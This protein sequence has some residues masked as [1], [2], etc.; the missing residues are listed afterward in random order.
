MVAVIRAVHHAHQHGVLHRD[1]KPSN[2]LVDSQGTRLV[3]DFGLAKRLADAELADRAGPAA[4]HP[5][6]HGPRAGRRPQGPDRRGRR[7]QPGRDPLRAIHRPDAVHGRQCPDAA[8]P[9]ARN[10]AAPAS[11]IRPG[12]TATWKRSSSSAWRR[13]RPVVP[14]C[15]GPGRRPR[16]LAGRQADHR[17]ADRVAGAG[18]EVGQAEPGGG[19]LCRPRLALLLV[20][21]AG[22]LDRWRPSGC[23]PPPPGRRKACTSRRSRSWSARPTRASPWCWPWR[24]PSATQARSPTTPYSP[25]WRPTMSCG[26]SSATTAR[27]RW[28]PSPPTAGPPLPGSDDRTARLWDLDSGRLLATLE[29]DAP[30]IA[31]RFRPD[32]RRL[33]T[34]SSKYYGPGGYSTNAVG[35]EDTPAK[36]APTVRVWDTSTGERLAA[37]PRP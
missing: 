13:T 11:S 27:S 10:G 25:R 34:F 5:A 4:R 16:S 7:L 36:D 33:V 12:W 2:V 14:E 35:P 30:L 6:V 32:G 17:P 37:W 29:H 22:R 18:L 19:G 20:A 23:R 1:L 26:P 28:S 9:G 31:V 21:L 8:P 24:Q 15:R 3:T